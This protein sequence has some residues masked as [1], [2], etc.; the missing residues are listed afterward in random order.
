LEVA[1][2]LFT[3]WLSNNMLISMACIAMLFVTSATR[4]HAQASVTLGA[5]VGY[6]ALQPSVRIT[7]TEGSFA[8]VPSTSISPHVV[9]AI[10]GRF[11]IARGVFAEV[12]VGG[13]G[14]S[15]A[16]AQRRDVVFGINGV[17]TPGI[18]RREV[19]FDYRWLFGEG[20]ALL[21]IGKL[22]HAE[23]GVGVHFQT[24]GAL[25]A[26]DVIESPSGLTFVNSG[27]NQQVLGSVVYNATAQPV[28]RAT[29]GLRH[30]MSVSRDV[31]IEPFVS[32]GVA[33][34]LQPSTPTAL[35]FDITLGLTLTL[36]RSSKVEVPDVDVLQRA[37]P[38]VRYRMVS[39]TTTE[40]IVGVVGRAD[41]SWTT[42]EVTDTIRTVENG[43]SVYHITT[44]RTTRRVVRRGDPPADIVLATQIVG[45][46]LR[47]AAKLEIR[48]QLISIEEALCWYAVII[49][50]DTVEQ[51]S[52]THYEYMV[53]YG[54]GELLDRVGDADSYTIE[55]VGWGQKLNGVRIRTVSESHEIVRSRDRR[56]LRIG[57]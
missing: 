14:G 38:M 10:G 55:V 21:D 23:V 45:V 49:N 57:R 6:R 19:A 43:T 46:P 15:V 56:L 18:I 53:A 36:D 41:T 30:M 40:E 34:K 31:W 16:A 47:S 28:I 4:L 9:F 12:R 54:L 42:T 7:H 1:I 51:H 35:P 22:Y 33:T 39:D 8:L 2:G 17:V 25:T 32:I 20:V 52:T 50:G 29:A 37:I 11:P 13:T 5:G 44:H 48:L 24:I 26:R 27:T 3:G